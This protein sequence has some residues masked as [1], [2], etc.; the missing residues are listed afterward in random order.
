L[1]REEFH[2]LEDGVRAHPGE[3]VHALNRA[4]G[5]VAVEEDPTVAVACAVHGGPLSPVDRPRNP[6]LG[7][8]PHMRYEPFPATF[9]SE[10]RARLA[11]R[12]PKDAIAIL[13]A[14]DVLTLSADG[15]L[16]Y[17]QDSDFFYLT[18]IEQEES[19]LILDPGAAAPEDRERLFLRETSDL[20][21][22]WEGDRLNREQATERS[23]IAR[24]D[25]TKDFRTGPASPDAPGEDGVPKRQR[26]S[27][28]RSG[29]DQPG[30]SLPQSPSGM[31][32]T[33]SIR[34]PRASPPRFARDQSHAGTRRHPR[35]LPDHRGRLRTGPQ[36]CPPGVTEFA[37]E[38][39][40]LHEFLRQR[41]RGFAYTPIIA[42][43]ANACVL[44]YIENNAVC[45]NGDLLLL[46]VAAEYARYH[47]D[48]TR[49]I[50]V[51]GRFTPR[52]RAVYEAVLRVM[53]CCITDLLRPGIDLK[54][55]Y[56]PAVGRIVERE[57]LG[58]GL[59]DPAKVAEERAKDGTPEE[60]KE[61]KRLYR[62]YFMH[63]TSHS[64]GLD[65]HDVQGR[66]RLVKEGMVYTVEPGIYI[67]EEGIGVRLETEVIVR[68]AGNED[69]MADV[70]IE[71]EEVEALMAAR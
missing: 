21:R 31:A 66:D 25:W 37:I 16:P 64:L 23:G 19:V 68:A 2:F 46:D 33:A 55:D 38:A 29:A 62:K 8:G 58:L 32:P 52:Q 3:F 63:G 24:V 28:F 5:A 53:R 59:L 22:I 15:T 49:T 50:P 11:A 36:V 13:H 4:E 71:V 42:S 26:T 20:I 12:L 40:F 43:G 54:K 56:Q 7:G 61:E 60:V 10:N 47:A 41:S 9:F 27:A 70:P 69:L 45:Q 51:N 14:H 6:G 67:R 34:A 48:L 30:R 18:G 44:H 17:R 1:V 57:L 65:V 39:E 35:G